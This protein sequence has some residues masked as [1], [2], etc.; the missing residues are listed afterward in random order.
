MVLSPR[1]LAPPFQATRVLRSMGTRAEGWRWSGPEWVWLMV[2]WVLMLLM[3]WILVLR[4]SHHQPPH[5]LLSLPPVVMKGVTRGT[6]DSNERRMWSE[7]GPSPT[8]VNWSSRCEWLKWTVMGPSYSLIITYVPLTLIL[9]VHECRER[10]SEG[11]GMNEWLK[12]KREEDS[13]DCKEPT[14]GPSFPLSFC[15]HSLFPTFIMAHR[16]HTRLRRVWTE[17][18]REKRCVKCRKSIIFGLL[19]LMS[20][21]KC[22]ERE[23]NERSEVTRPGG[24]ARDERGG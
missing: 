17:D 2:D 5:T 7:T 20:S 6:T 23:R 1:T 19:F 22:T 16:S 13:S 9:T 12:H 4:H 8:W 11:N 3:D 18:E 15:F 24:I 10:V 21:P 14:D